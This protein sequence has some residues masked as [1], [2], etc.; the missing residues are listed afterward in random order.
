HGSVSAVDLLYRIAFV[1][2]QKEMWIQNPYLAPDPEMLELLAQAAERGA[3]VR[4]MLPGKV[5]D[6][7][8]VRHAGHRHFA[9][10]LRRGVHIYE[11]QRTLIHQ[12]VMI[13][14][15]LWSHLGSTNLDNRSFESNDEV[16]LGIVDA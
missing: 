8:I 3:D 7:Q 11:Y 4:I 12:K 15:S 13:V 5:T 2:A 9:E 6:A 14:D 16:S 1:S 10:L